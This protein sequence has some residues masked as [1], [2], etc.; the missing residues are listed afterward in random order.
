MVWAQTDGD[1]AY[2]ASDAA[3]AGAKFQSV[4]DAGS[5]AAILEPSG[6]IHKI[7]RDGDTDV[8]VC[9]ALGYHYLNYGEKIHV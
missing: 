7:N 3:D 1:Y 8:A 4:S 9:E 5:A 2:A 6:A